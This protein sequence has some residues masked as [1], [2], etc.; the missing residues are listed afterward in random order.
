MTITKQTFQRLGYFNEALPCCIDRDYS[1][2]AMA[3]GINV[4][5]ASDYCVIHLG[6]DEHTL[7]ANERHQNELYAQSVSLESTHFASNWE[8]V[9]DKILRAMKK[10]TIVNIG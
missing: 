8:K 6:E 9:A 7:P 2:R 5:Y 4:G 10:N 1:Q 3:E